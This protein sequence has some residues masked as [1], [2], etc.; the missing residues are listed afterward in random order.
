MSLQPP[1]ADVSSLIRQLDD[2]RYE[3]LK[4][5]ATRKALSDAARGLAFAIETPGDTI[6]RIAFSV[7]VSNESQQLRH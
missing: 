7:R 4:D 2:F 6:Q 5:D 1:E 3:T